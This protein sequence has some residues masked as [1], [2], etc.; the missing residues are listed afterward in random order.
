[1]EVSLPE[2]RIYTVLACFQAAF[3]M[4]GTFAVR[5]ASSESFNESYYRVPPA[6]Y[7]VRNW[8]YLLLLLPL[9]CLVWA[10]QDMRDDP[11]GHRA[12]KRV[13]IGVLVTVAVGA[14]FWGVWELS[15][16]RNHGVG[17]TGNM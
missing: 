15:M 14:F 4:V 6:A 12:W 7:L 5:I 1:M 11:E 9:G 10:L 13:L 8:G 2:H 17:E 3:V 16:H